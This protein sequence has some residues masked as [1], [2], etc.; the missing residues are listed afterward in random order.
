[1]VYQV[2][3]FFASHHSL[4]F[5]IHASLMTV[6]DICATDRCWKM[7]NP[8]LADIDLEYVANSLKCAR[9]L[10]IAV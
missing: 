2:K 6:H 4:T 1:M 10:M 8:R 3:Q 7:C 5:M 9:G